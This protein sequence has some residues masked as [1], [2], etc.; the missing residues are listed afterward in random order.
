MWS[1]GIDV[2]VALVAGAMSLPRKNVLGEESYQVRS[3]DQV[4]SS[5]GVRMVFLRNR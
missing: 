4:L 3:P 1:R 5:S 2:E